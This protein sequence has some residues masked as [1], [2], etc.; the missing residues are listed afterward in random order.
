[1]ERDPLVERLEALRSGRQVD[2]D[3][4]GPPSLGWKP[5]R[6]SARAAAADYDTSSGIHPVDRGPMTWPDPDTIVQRAAT[7][8]MRAR[9]PGLVPKLFETGPLPGVPTSWLIMGDFL[10]LGSLLASCTLTAMALGPVGVLVP[11]AMESVAYAGGLLITQ[12][13]QGGLQRAQRAAFLQEEEDPETGVV[14]EEAILQVL[15]EDAE[16]ARRTNLPLAVLVIGVDGTPDV[17]GLID[18]GAGEPLLAEMA[19]RTRAVLRPEDSLGLHG[20]RQLLAVITG[21]D[22]TAVALL[23]ERVRL[24]VASMPFQLDGTLLPVTVSV[25]VAWTDAAALARPADLVKRATQALF[26]AQMR[27]R[28]RVVVAGRAGETGQERMGA[29][30][31]VGTP[32]RPAPGAPPAGGQTFAVGP[33]GAGPASGPSVGGVPPSGAGQS[34]GPTVGVVPPPGSRPPGRPNLGA[35]PAGGAPGAGARPPFPPPNRPST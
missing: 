4:P 5:G 19:R 2:S 25:G 27:G 28:N 3:R 20:S 9:S 18:Q 10:A 8:T 34:G 13:T 14:D 23:A 32:G 21:F 22:P 17:D 15:Q 35:P 12:A 26:R 29:T 6:A 30:L 24:A 16:M 11:L 31:G 1:M 33:P 7:D